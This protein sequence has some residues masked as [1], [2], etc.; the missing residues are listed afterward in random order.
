MLRERPR[1]VVVA[2]LTLCV[3]GCEKRG[4][5]SRSSHV[6]FAEVAARH[7]VAIE[8][9]R[10]HVASLAGGI[11]ILGTDEDQVR[12]E[13]KVQIRRKRANNES[14]TGEFADHVRL[15]VADGQ[16]TIADAHMDQP[17]NDDWRVSLVVHAPARLGTTVALTAGRIRVADMQADLD[18]DT[19]GGEIV[20]RVG[21]VGAVT[22]FVAG[23]SIDIQAKAIGGPVDAS[24]DGGQVS[25]RVSES[26]PTADVRLCTTAG[27]VT[28]ELPKGSPG[29]FQATSTVGS[30][31]MPD[32][33]GVEVTRTGLGASAQ[34]TIGQGGPT[35][36]LSTTT[37]EVVVR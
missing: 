12:V 17:D 10:L 34:G 6:P 8:V 15:E 14:G 27:R 35:Y 30:V 37:G 18:L 28:L 2:V 4:G 33:G 26:P 9:T 21:Q 24:V 20:V 25:L 16:L 32:W 13:A 36:K 7:P 19:K 5:L 29:T 31:S 23:G 1:Y 3:V 11:E 22:A